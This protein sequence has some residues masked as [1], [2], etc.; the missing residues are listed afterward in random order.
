MFRATCNRTL[1]HA[2]FNLCA[3]LD[4]TLRFVF[5]NFYWSVAAL[6]CR[7]VSAAR[8]WESGIHRDVPPL[9]QHRE[10]S[11][12]LC[13]HLNGKG[14]QKRGTRDTNRLPWSLSGKESCQC[15]KQISIPGWEDH[16]EKEMATH[17]SILAWE[18]PWTE[19]P[20][21]LQSMRLQK[22]QT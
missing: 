8:Q 11:S 14:I 3:S 4:T 5:T 21:G 1:L 7:I 6:P 17:S 9:L 19:E 22:T 13:D 15:R 20:G 10:L 18:I 2:S 16:L 12:M